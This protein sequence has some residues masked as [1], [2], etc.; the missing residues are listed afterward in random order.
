MAI[1][2]PNWIAIMTRRSKAPDLDDA[3]APRID[4]ALPDIWEDQP[5]LLPTALLSNPVK[6]HVGPWTGSVEGKIDRVQLYID[7]VLPAGSRSWTC[8]IAPDDFWVEIA[9]ELLVDGVATLHYELTTWAGNSDISHYIRFTVDTRPP[10]FGTGLGEVT[11]PAD[12]VGATIT[13]IYLIAHDEKVRVSATLHT[14]PLQGDVITWYLGTAQNEDARVASHKLTAA[15]LGGPYPIDLQGEFLRGLPE[16]DYLLWTRITDR[17][18]NHSTWSVSTTVTLRTTPIP[19]EL[20]AARLVEAVQHAS[21]WVL[22]PLSLRLGGNVELLAQAIVHPGERVR[23]EL[24]D[25]S[26][27]ATYVSEYQALP[28]NRRFALDR[29]RFAPYVGGR[30]M[31][32]MYRVDGLTRAG[33]AR[34]EHPSTLQAITVARLPASAVQPVHCPNAASTPGFLYLGNASSGATFEQPIWTFAELGQ[35]VRMRLEG[36]THFELVPDR[37]LA[38]AD[39]DRSKV[40]GSI[41]AEDLRKLALNRHFEVKVEVSFDGGLK[42]VALR[43]LSL[44]LVA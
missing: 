31:T 25:P 4:G 38:Q 27:H 34:I 1:P 24:H 33:Q 23:V 8:P 18:G 36:S 32:L 5:N 13:D 17:A 40:I 9:P 39:L 3:P 14:Q 21:D 2:F 41:S 37:G 44:Q 15:E 12:L 11:L 26:G 35:R 16:G 29:Q 7:T 42:F 6:V 28:A 30:V 19:R 20:P 43:T 10:V 22:D